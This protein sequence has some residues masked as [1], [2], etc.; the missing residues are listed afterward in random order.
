MA[1][2]RE[3]PLTRCPW[4]TTAPLVGCSS[5]AKRR[6][7]VVLP[8]PDGP[9]MHRNSPS[10]TSKLTSSRIGRP[11]LVP[12][13]RPTFWTDIVGSPPATSG[14]ARG[15][16]ASEADTHSS[17]AGEDRLPLLASVRQ[18]GLERAELPNP[19]YVKGNLVRMI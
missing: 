8:H 14:C 13:V 15:T 7:S 4:K 1:R 16:A 5:P 12:N 9:T 6:S 10:S 18:P 17:R 11:R 19:Y 2:E 3:G